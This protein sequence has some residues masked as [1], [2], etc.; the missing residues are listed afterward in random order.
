M[1]GLTFVRCRSPTGPAH[2]RWW[3]H[4]PSDE[5]DSPGV[6][7]GLCW[8]V[9]LAGARE[10]AAAA[11]GAAQVETARMHAATKVRTRNMS[12]SFAWWCH[13]RR[14][15]VCRCRRGDP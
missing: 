1:P 5:L 6:V 15:L 14:S 8:R 9:T 4:I 7:A 10:T 13:D 11:G 12:A 2:G 3:Y